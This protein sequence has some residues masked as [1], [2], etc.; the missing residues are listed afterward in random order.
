MVTLLQWQD[1]D[2]KSQSYDYFL[3]LW[4]VLSTC[5]LKELKM[6]FTLLDWGSL[7]ADELEKA[8]SQF[9]DSQSSLEIM[10]LEINLQST[11]FTIELFQSLTGFFQRNIFKDLIV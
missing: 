9:F 2:K 3:S 10:W 1:Q 4:K 8:I 11:D 7:G 5:K 6:D